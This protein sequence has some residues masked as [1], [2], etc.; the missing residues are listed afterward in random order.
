MAAPVYYTADKVRG[1]A[2]GVVTATQMALGL[3]P[4]AAQQRPGPAPSS[5]PPADLPPAWEVE[6]SIHDEARMDG[7]GSVSVRTTDYKGMK[8]SVRALPDMSVD[9]ARQLAGEFRQVLDVQGPGHVDQ[10]WWGPPSA[11][12]TLPEPAWAPGQR[13]LLL[14]RRV[15]VKS[16]Q[17]LLDV[18]TAG[19]RNMPSN[20]GPNMFVISANLQWTPTHWQS[21][22]YAP[23]R[24]TTVTVPPMDEGG[25]TMTLPE[26]EV[27]YD[28]RQPVSNNGGATYALPAYTFGGFRTVKRTI[29]YTITRKP[30]RVLYG[31]PRVS[32]I[33]QLLDC[34]VCKDQYA[35]PNYAKGEESGILQVD[36]STSKA[37]D[38]WKTTYRFIH[39]NV[40]LHL[41]IDGKDVTNFK[42]IEGGREMTFELLRLRRDWVWP[43]DAEGNLGRGPNGQPAGGIHPPNDPETRQFGNGWFDDDPTPGNFKDMPGSFQDRVPAGWES[44]RETKEFLI[45]VKNFP[46]F[47]FYYYAITFETRPGQF[48]FGQSPDASELKAEEW[49]GR[50]TNPSATPFEQVQ[51]GPWVT[52]FVE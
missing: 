46:E 15:E 45:A 23:P 33:G 49:C 27:P 51:L 41:T 19:S 3:M 13:E 20:G 50:V 12:R 40:D 4:A 47:G 17:N 25:P 34:K 26:M 30:M 5:P 52:R 1:I 11:T 42:M 37:G 9:P 8:Y 24:P 39:G 7:A 48:R 10:V 32:L 35:N 18:Q 29:D 36:G 44:E 38:P 2:A 31:D 22:I 21:T 43:L 6:F 28:F 14:G 16:C